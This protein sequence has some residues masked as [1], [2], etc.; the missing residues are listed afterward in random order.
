YV[1]AASQTIENL[2]KE[3][4]KVQKTLKKVS[5]APESLSQQIEATSKELKEMKTKLVGD[6]ELGFRGMRFSVQGGLFMLGRAIGGYT[7]APSDRQLQ[8]IE[9]KKQALDVLIQRI[10]KII[11]E[12][13]PRLNRLLNENNIPHM[14]PGKTIKFNT[15]TGS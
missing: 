13:M 12:D 5:D 6:P 15:S 2:N 7:A 8:Q 9:E 14:F 11:E 1:S 4:D 3:L 10:N